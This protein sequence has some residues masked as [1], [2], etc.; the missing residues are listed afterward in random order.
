MIPP[1]RVQNSPSP[2]T[3]PPQ[4]RGRSSPEHSSPELASVATTLFAVDAVVGDFPPLGA[5]PA[6][7]Q[8][9]GAGK[10]RQGRR[11]VLEQPAVLAARKGRRVAPTAISVPTPAARAGNIG[12]D[13]FGQERFGADGGAAESGTPVWP[14][15]PA[16]GG[17]GKGGKGKGKGQGTGRP[18]ADLLAQRMGGGG[19]VGAWGDAQDA[20]GAE[21]GAAKPGTPVWAGRAASASDGGGGDHAEPALAWPGAGGGGGAWGAA[22]GGGALP[23]DVLARVKTP[24][25][26]RAPRDALPGRRPVLTLELPA[27]PA[28]RPA[29]PLDISA[30]L[31]AMQM[32]MRPLIFEL[33]P[34]GEAPASAGPQHMELALLGD[35]LGAG[36]TFDV[37]SADLLNGR[38]SA[39]ARLGRGG[40]EVSIP[41]PVRAAVPRHGGGRTV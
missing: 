12:Q 33:G 25:H 39:G 6:R 34:L 4:P 19:A 24:P 13:R 10:G 32:Q 7:G 15:R 17:R 5:S 22:A 16:A 1:P 28:P 23:D 3:P 27:E 8:P 31:P 11:V 35:G 36:A 20:F 14:G 37:A 30:G 18:V 29:M 41:D 9:G 40:R 26:G 21:A 2:A 38:R